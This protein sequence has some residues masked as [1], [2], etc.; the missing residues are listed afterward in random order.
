M[1]QYNEYPDTED[2]HMIYNE[3]N[4]IQIESAKTINII[5]ETKN[6]INYLR[7]KKILIGVTTGF[8][9][10]ITDIIKYINKFS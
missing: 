9:K 7:E 4:N 2:I 8:N 1:N 3:F 6:I 10:E 5:P